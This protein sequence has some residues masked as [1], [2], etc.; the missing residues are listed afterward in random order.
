MVPLGELVNQTPTFPKDAQ[1]GYVPEL[2]VD[3]KVPAKDFDIVVAYAVQ[4]KFKENGH[5]LVLEENGDD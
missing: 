4:Q 2:K 3:I 5:T 1:G